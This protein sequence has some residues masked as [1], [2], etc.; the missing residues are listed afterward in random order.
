ML[1]IGVVE[2]P[3]VFLEQ[4]YVWEKCRLKKKECKGKVRK[5]LQTYGILN[6]NGAW[7][8]RLCEYR[9]VRPLCTYIVIIKSPENLKNGWKSE[10]SKTK[11][12]T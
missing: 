7:L 5:V 2:K 1:S 12:D 8:V 3:S 10:R 11:S 4:F 9:Q 6:V